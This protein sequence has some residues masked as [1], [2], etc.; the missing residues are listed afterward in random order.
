MVAG[1]PVVV[2]ESLA[3]CC[4]CILLEKY[5]RRKVERC[6]REIE[7]CSRNLDL[8]KSEEHSPPKESL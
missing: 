2:S 6:A 1:E 4:T 5:E 8:D 3:S 7:H